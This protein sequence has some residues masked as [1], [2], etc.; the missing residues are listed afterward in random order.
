MGN[1]NDSTGHLM[2]F[3][4]TIIT[5]LLGGLL[6]TACSSFLETPTNRKTP[7]TAMPTATS[8][9]PG[10]EYPTA[11]LAA[12]Q[13]LSAMLGI[14]PGE[15]VLI[16]YLSASWNDAC[17]NLGGADEACAEVATPG[18][19]VVLKSGDRF[20]VFHTNQD[21]SQIRQELEP[22][23][24]PQAALEARQALAAR[25]DLAH[26]LLVSVISVEAVNWPDAC[27][28]ISKAGEMCA[29]V[30]T[31]GYRVLLEAG[32]KQYEYHTDETGG[33]VVL[34]ENILS[35][36]GKSA[37]PSLTWQSSIDPCL[38]VEI[39]GLGA[40]YADCDN[41]SATGV[42][43]NQR[44]DELAGWLINFAPFQ[45]E[46]AAGTIELLGEGTRTATPA[47]QRAVAEWAR[48]VLAELQSDRSSAA[49]G[50]A[51]AW[52]RE[53]GL[54]GFCSD[55]MVYTYGAV[56]ATDCTV[57]PA[58][59][60]SLQLE[61][62]QLEQ[63]YAWLDEFQSIEVDQTDPATADAMTEELLLNGTGSQLADEADQQSLIDFVMTLFQQAMQ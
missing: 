49:Q 41:L 61:S 37:A 28:G 15:I 51:L 31:P 35:F 54:A 24:L 25:L 16:G 47:E 58:E 21:G 17:L 6:L 18:Y 5:L 11:I 4:K 23:N 50:L 42:L 10:G 29:Q 60:R 46:T 52:H 32:G 26:E 45:A 56:L 63:L 44:A 62:A 27:L 30:I 19:Q 36:S 33:R 39:N 3:R 9:L 55:I 1:I 57:E 8:I 38:Q 53:G 40:T 14:D 22:A 7:L 13:A 12:Q 48:V 20:Y 59:T 43:L 2:N 34:L